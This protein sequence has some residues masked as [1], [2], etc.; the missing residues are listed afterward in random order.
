MWLDAAR[1]MKIG[2][3]AASGGMTCEILDFWGHYTLDKT[4]DDPEGWEVQNLLTVA[5]LVAKSALERD[6]SVGVH[7]RTDAPEGRPSSAY[8]VSSE[9]NPDGTEPIRIALATT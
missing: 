1:L 8:Q 7:F 9:R 4:L 5:R 6:D 2:G 3:S